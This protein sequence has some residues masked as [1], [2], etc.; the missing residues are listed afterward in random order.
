MTSQHRGSFLYSLPRIAAW[1]LLIGMTCAAT[2]KACAQD[3]ARTRQL[4]LLCAQLSGD[5]TDPGGIA[6]FR[7]C[8]STHNPLGEIARD[9]NIGARAPAV[10]P[11]RPA[12]RP[13]AG[14]GRDSRAKLAEGVERFATRDPA[15]FLA[16]DRDARLWRFN[17]QT[18][19]AKT[20]A[21][22]VA[23]GEPT[24]GGAV[25][26][27]GTDGRLWRGAADDPARQWIDDMVASFKATGPFIYVLGKDGKLWREAGTSAS[28]VLVDQR[29]A[30]FQA[31]D[32]K[33]VFVLGTDGVLWRER[34]DARDRDT[35]ASGVAAFDHVSDGDTTE[36]LTR[37]ATLWRQVGATGKPE[38]IDHDVAAFEAVDA[39]QS[40]VL[41]R[42]GRLWLERGTRDHAELVDTEVSTAIGRA[43]F[44]APD[45]RHV[46]VLTND[47]KL[48]A[49]TMPPAK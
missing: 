49:E 16:I 14:F 35:V 23:A 45:A 36:V 6:A 2:H 3:D 26:I 7:R 22:H 9:N 48:W 24:E 41:G 15:L 46:Y 19:D 47:H 30:S 4:R 28:R 13:P 40:Y 5:L 43:A 34:G 32:D 1:A 8:L 11:D 39:R 27:L 29:V 33:L 37:D 25:L 44:H 18:K 20:I 38:Q 21:E 10:A 12:A 17:P 42:D 31:V